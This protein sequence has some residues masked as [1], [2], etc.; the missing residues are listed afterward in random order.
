M[1]VKVGMVAVVALAAEQIVRLVE[2]MG[3]AGAPAEIVVKDQI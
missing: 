3:V 2:G 1:I